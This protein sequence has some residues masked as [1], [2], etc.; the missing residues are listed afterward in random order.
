MLCSGLD[1][2]G[3]RSVL[4]I[5]TL[6]SSVG[7]LP[8]T[9]ECTSS[10]MA[11]FHAKGTCSRSSSGQ[12]KAALFLPAH[13]PALKRTQPIERR[14]QVRSAELEPCRPTDEVEEGPEHAVFFTATAAP[15]ERARL[16]LLICYSASVYE[17]WW[18]RSHRK[19]PSVELDLSTRKSVKYDQR[20]LSRAP[21]RPAASLHTAKNSRTEFS[22][23]GQ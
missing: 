23:V 14:R 1:W 10:I 7:E 12:R 15:E 6:P 4:L 11:P 16:L 13:P 5:P 22:L 8:T 3:S 9:H 17:S 2:I 18:F 21:V 20:I 19:R